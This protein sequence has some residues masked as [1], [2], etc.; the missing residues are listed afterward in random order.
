MN[1]KSLLIVTAVVEVG[2]GLALVSVPSLTAEVL[3]GEGLVPPPALVVARVAG[4]AVISLSVACWLERNG[5]GRAQSGLVAGMLIYNIAVPIV[6]FHAWIIFSLSGI[7]L[8]PASVLH[9]ALGIWCIVC[10]R[11]L[12]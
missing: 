11:R 1:T 9:A 12:R 4:A 5:E 7:G 2:A 10:L 8:W 6:L 3:L